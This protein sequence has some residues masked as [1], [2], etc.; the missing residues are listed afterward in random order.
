MSDNEEEN[1]SNAGSEQPEPLGPPEPV[2]KEQLVKGL[3]RIQRTHG[4]Q[5]RFDLTYVNFGKLFRWNILCF[6]GVDIGGH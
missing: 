2:K 5:S 6:L 4:K 1:K 3:S